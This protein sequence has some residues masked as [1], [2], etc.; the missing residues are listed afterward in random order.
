MHDVAR[1]IR[2]ALYAFS[3]LQ[4][5]PSALRTCSLEASAD[6]T[7]WGRRV[8]SAKSSNRNTSWATWCPGTLMVLVEYD[9]RH[10]VIKRSQT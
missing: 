2:P 9:S 5:S 3:C 4:R 7:V 10:G 8:A 1:R 6:P